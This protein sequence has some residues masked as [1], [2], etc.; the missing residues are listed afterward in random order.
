MHR[1]RFIIAIALAG[2]ALCA[3]RSAYAT[4]YT[5]FLQLEIKHGTDTT[6]S[7]TTVTTKAF[8]LYA[9]LTPV[10]GS[11]S[12]LSALLDTTS[13]IAAALTP[14]V[15]VGQDLGS[16]SFNSNVVRATA[17]MVYGNPP[18]EPWT[19]ASET[20]GDMVR[21]DIY[22]SYFREFSLKSRSTTSAIACGGA[23]KNISCASAYDATGATSTMAPTAW[24]SDH[25]MYYQAFEV[26][27]SALNPNYEVHV[28]VYS[29]AA[30]SDGAQGR[31]I[32]YLAKA[33]RRGADR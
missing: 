18:F 5:P 1:L 8:T 10:A 33:V 2:A 12:D 4:S 26:D 11:G 19:A 16:F 29:V 15:Y 32:K 9:Y 3:P 6:T 22:N 27:T 20:T 7:R 21:S 24:T 14:K 25:T 23:G 30:G 13:Y 28:D 17:D 31:N